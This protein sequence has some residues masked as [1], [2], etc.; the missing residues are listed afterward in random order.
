MK[1]KRIWGMSRREFYGYV[2][3]TA[4]LLVLLVGGILVLAGVIK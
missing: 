1:K 3:A 2:T 4:L